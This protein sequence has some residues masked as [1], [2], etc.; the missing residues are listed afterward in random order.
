VSPTARANPL[1][2]LGLSDNTAEK[3]SCGWVEIIS[4]SAS[5]EPLFD[6]VFLTLP[7]SLLSVRYR[8]F[9]VD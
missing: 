9:T 3:R 6:D 2:L 7:A 4:V 8:Q 1:V 5:L